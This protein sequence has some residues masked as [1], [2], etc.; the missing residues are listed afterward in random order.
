M[1][2]TAYIYNISFLQYIRSVDR[3]VM[4]V[5]EINAANASAL[6]CL[7]VFEYIGRVLS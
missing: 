7:R 3:C 2:I 5:L 1:D 6:I 4:T